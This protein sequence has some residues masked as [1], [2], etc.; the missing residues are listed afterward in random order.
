MWEGQA[1]EQMM[2]AILTHYTKHPFPKDV[3]HFIFNVLII[4]DK[5]KGPSTS[6]CMSNRYVQKVCQAHG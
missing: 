6:L 1:A 5:V 4:S 3:Q 2:Q